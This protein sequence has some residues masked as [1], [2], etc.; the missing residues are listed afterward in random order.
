MRRINV[1]F[2]IAAIVPLLFVAASASAQTA[3]SPQPLVVEKI[4]T[5]WVLAP[6]FKATEVDNQFGQLAGAYAGRV[7]DDTV[8]L[9]GAGYWLVNGSDDFKLAYGGL[10]LGWNA[11]RTGRVRFGA[12]SLVGVGT[13]TLGRNIDGILPRGSLGEGGFFGRDGG[14]DPIIRFGGGR[15]PAATPIG[16]AMPML[17]RTS[18]P[19]SDEFFVI[20]PQ[21]NVSFNLSERIALAGAVGYRA[22]ASTD[23]LRDL[24]N[25]PTVGLG[26]QFGW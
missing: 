2:R 7:T 17:P 11:D 19:I 15:Q 14:R 10:L 9:A 12:R 18:V 1:V 8:L 5:G 21:A 20:E 25:G 22:T 3:P 4:P 6:D 13:A 26:L 16:R 23:G 24:I